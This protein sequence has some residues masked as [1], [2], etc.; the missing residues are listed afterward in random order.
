MY[1]KN[2][3][4]NLPQIHMSSQEQDFLWCHQCQLGQIFHT[5]ETKIPEKK[6]K[7]L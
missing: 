5:D 1:R 3:N 7:F 6:K 4:T 2:N